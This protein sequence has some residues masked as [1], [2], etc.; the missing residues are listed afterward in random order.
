MSYQPNFSGI[1]AKIERAKEHLDAFDRECGAQVGTPVPEA[2]RVPMT[3]KYE[4]S[5]GYHVFRATPI[6]PEDAIRR[7]GIIVGDIAHNARSALDHLFWQLALVH[8]DENMPWTEREQRQIQFPITDTPDKFAGN[9]ARKFVASE[10]WTRIEGHQPY[11]G[12]F[13][14]A[15]AFLDP[16][17]RLREFSNTDKHR[18]ITPVT[19]LSNRHTDV[20]ELF[21]DAGGR[22]V[23]L[24]RPWGEDG[25]WLVEEDAEVMRVLV[26]PASLQL[27]MDMA[28]YVVPHPSVIDRF[29][30]GPPAAF[31]CTGY[32]AKLCLRY[33]V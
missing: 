25:A 33:L 32:L 13:D 31:R 3:C 19:M 14:E 22:V 6:L 8:C 30:E 23:R 24:D 18:V 4:P 15:H 1:W 21:H 9:R 17:A 27:D 29:P 28:G 5:S 20:L 16:L 12:R 26:E 11:S 2:Y 7:L 10:H